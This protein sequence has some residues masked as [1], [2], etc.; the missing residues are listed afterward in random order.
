VRRQDQR[1]IIGKAQRLGRNRQPL[2]AHRLDLGEQCPGID[3]D[4]AADDRQ[5]AGAHDTRRQQ[6]QLVLDIADNQRMPGIV[7]AL[8]THDHIGALR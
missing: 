7:A 5:L 1:R 4:A 2:A 8:E 6:A 3:D